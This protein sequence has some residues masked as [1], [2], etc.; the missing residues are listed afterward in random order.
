M[1]NKN[2]TNGLAILAAG[3]FAPSISSFL[4]HFP[5]LSNTTDLTAGFFDGLATVAFVVAIFV[6]VR[7]R[8]D[9]S[10]KT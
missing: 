2:F 9:R 7:S 10:D 3:L 8:G 1:N 5:V 4:E 6:L